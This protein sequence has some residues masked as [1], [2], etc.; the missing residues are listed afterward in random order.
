MIISI[1]RLTIKIITYFYNKVGNKDS[2]NDI[3]GDVV[4][5]ALLPLKGYSVK[6][7]L[8]FLLSYGVQGL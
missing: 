5:Q 2:Y 4:C 3:F 6:H 7:R 1:I 8:A